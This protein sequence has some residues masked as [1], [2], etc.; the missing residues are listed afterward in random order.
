M[1]AYVLS[2][3]AGTAFVCSPFMTYA[4][5]ADYTTDT[6]YVQEHVETALAKEEPTSTTI[7]SRDELDR[8]AAHNLHDALAGQQSVHI[9]TDDMG[10]STVSIRGAEA[11]H[12]LILVDGRRQMGGLSKFAGA[13]DE[14]ERI[15]VDNVD[16]IQIMRGAESAR[17]GSDAIGGVVNVVTKM[18]TTSGGH[19]SWEQFP[20]A[21]GG[22]QYNRMVTVNSGQVGSVRSSFSFGLNKTAPYEYNDDGSSMQYFGYRRPME[23]AVE[24]DLAKNQTLSL[25]KHKLTEDLE[26]KTPAG[27]YVQLHG[28]E[29]GTRKNDYITYKG[30]FGKWDVSLQNYKTDYDATYDVYVFPSESAPFQSMRNA[31]RDTVRHIDKVWEGKF[32]YTP[33]DAHYITAS[34]E[35]HTETGRGTRIDVPGSD[36]WDM[37]HV[38]SIPNP[39][40]PDGVTLLNWQ[41]RASEATI[42]NTS[43]TISDDWRIGGNWLIT[44]AIR[45]DRNSKFKDYVSTKIGV[46][47]HVNAGLKVKANVGTGFTTPGVAE[48]YH[49]WEMYEPS[50]SPKSPFRNGWFF[51]GNPNLKPEKSLN[52]DLSAEIERGRTSSKLTLFRND[53]KDFMQIVYDGERPSK[54]LN[55]FTHWLTDTRVYEPEWAEWEDI[56][57]YNELVAALQDVSANGDPDEL[58]DLIHDTTDYLHGIPAMDDVF[59]YKNIAKARLQGVEWDVTHRF[60]SDFSV[61]AGYTYLDARDR[62]TGKRLEGRGKHMFNLNLSYNDRKHGIRATLWGHYTKNYLDIRDRV[63]TGRLIGKGEEIHTGSIDIYNPKNDTVYHIHPNKESALG[64][65]DFRDKEHAFTKEKV[66]KEKNYGVW[67]FLLEK[68]LHEDFTIYVGMNNIFDKKDNYLGLGGRV[69]R[70]GGRIRF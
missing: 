39:A 13:V 34:I 22:M 15:N 52:I 60:G 68:D 27:T 21:S 32:S 20:L 58:D 8:K 2:I 50:L 46:T 1:K 10:R 5:S 43:F 47:R 30:Q 64:Q 29:N 53:I 59:T 36:G 49:S 55:G 57:D 65:S 51:Q 70:I 35:H 12:T 44:P 19:I 24:I 61:T 23:G 26:K 45:Y 17:F 41:G 66:A 9:G 42:N 4:A 40:A 67:N 16:H 38:F 56:Y 69:Y 54:N 3:L 33:S 25:G 37:S 63:E 14:M 28:K 7:V 48:L 6:I 62:E 18:S 11:R 31:Y